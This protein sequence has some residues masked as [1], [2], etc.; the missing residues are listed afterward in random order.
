MSNAN[1]DYVIVY[2]VK[3]SSLVLSRP[4]IFYITDKNTSNIFVKL[5]TRVSVG[6]GVDQYTD[7]EKASNYALT[8]RVVKPNNEVK[9]LKAT[10]HEPESIFQFDLTE[11]FKDIP[12]KYICELTISTVV[13]SRQELITSDPFSYE[14]K[15]S[16]LSN[17][18]EIIETE[19]TT[20]EKLLN[21]VDSAISLI[22]G[23][24][25]K[26]EVF[27]V[28]NGI[29]INDF[30]EATRRTFLEAQGIDVNYVLGDKAVKHNNLADNSVKYNHLSP[31]TPPLFLAG[32]NMYENLLG[33][34]LFTEGSLYADGTVNTVNTNYYVSH[35][36]GIN[37]GKTYYRWNTDRTV[38]VAYYDAN[39]TFISRPTI[40]SG[41]ISFV[42]P[43][44]AYYMRYTDAKEKM[45]NEIIS[46]IP[47]TKHHNYV[48]SIYEFDKH[49]ALGDN[50]VGTEKL[51]SKSITRDLLADRIL[52]VPDFLADGS[53]LNTLSK[54]GYFVCTNCANKPDG[55]G[56]CFLLNRVFLNAPGNARW[57][58]QEIVD[59]TDPSNRYIRIIDLQ[60]PANNKAWTKSLK[61]KS[62]FEGKKLITIGDSITE[63]VG[64]SNSNTTYPVYINIK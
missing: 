1:R 64:A 54:D 11:D 48:G 36:I 24:P 26:S 21:R 57:A 61:T 25:D 28:Q 9:S 46:S 31:G 62:K 8:M 58:M 63:G 19:N 22:N 40:E 16:I 59:F 14:V 41:T 56:T 42:V 60:Q 6:N 29:N 39:K 34:S 18:G 47:I 3:N 52:G 55:M 45:M 37:P 13:S 15:R 23:K 20:V 30:D 27:L 49:Y 5:V 38:V 33:A 53:D 12:G 17:V 4:L 44:N 2:D 32:V 35:Y 7:I 51:K 43:S 50:T 10:Q